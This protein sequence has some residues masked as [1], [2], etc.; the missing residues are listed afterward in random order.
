MRIK[1]NMFKNI[2]ILILILIVITFLIIQQ[3]KISEPYTQ[4]NYDH[5]TLNK[6]QLNEMKELLQEFIN[7]SNK[8]D[9]RY[10]LIA[11]S[12]L[13]LERNGGLMPTDD[14]IDIGV[15][16]EDDHKIKKYKNGNYYF[17]PMIFG[18]QFKNKNSKMFIDIM[19][20]K[21]NKHTN[22]YSVINYMLRKE[23]FKEEELLP[24]KIKMYGTIPVYVPNNYYDYLDRVYPKWN[25]KVKLQC[26]HVDG[27]FTSS[28]F[29]KCIWHKH[30]IPKEFD[31]TYDNSKYMC[32]VPL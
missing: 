32:Y 23:T 1:N 25:E 22:I 10:F 7:F 5:L 26:G 20:Y 8:N 19:L 30:D 16:N 29:S 9:V 6:T 15:L 14:D 17:R 2:Y 3:N 28:F 4:C 27:Y 21:K 24:L 13:G 12:L 11:G 31:V 18:Y